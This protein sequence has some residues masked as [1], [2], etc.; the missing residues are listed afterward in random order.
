MAAVVRN[1]GCIEVDA[2]TGKAIRGTTTT[3]IHFLPI[4]PGSGGFIG[5]GEKVWSDQM[6][7]TEWARLRRRGE[8]TIDDE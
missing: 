7:K 4:E 1:P 6:L 3:P 8:I 2:A 5:S